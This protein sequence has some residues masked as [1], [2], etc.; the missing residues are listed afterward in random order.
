MDVSSTN[1]NAATAAGTQARSTLSA[2]MDTFLKLL[3][4]QLQNQD[5]LSPMDTNQFTQQLVMYSQVEQQIQTNDNLS[6]LIAMQKSAAGSNAVGYLG[7]TAYTQG[8]STSLADGAAN[9]RYTMPNDAATVTLTVADANGKT[10]YTTTGEGDLGNHDFTWDGKNSAGVAQANGTY[11]L[12]IS[13]KAADGTALTPTIEG[14]GVV[15]ELD[16]STATPQV[17]VG[18]RKVDL[19]DIVGL[20]N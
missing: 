5:P 16:M 3:T 19:T 15:K 9:W 11:T 12:S 2:N 4:S 17:T 7:R 20:K 6:S 8:G 13:A 10:V 1:N 14:V 18:S